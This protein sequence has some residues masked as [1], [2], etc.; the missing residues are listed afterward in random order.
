MKL[1]RSFL[2][3]NLAIVFLSTS[4]VLGR[5]IQMEP[6][7]T[8]WWRCIIALVIMFG[9]VKFMKLE[10]KPKKGHK[11]VIF[12]SAFLLAVHW[13]AYFY[14]LYLSNIAITL[15]A[16]HT[17]PTMTALLEPLI[18]KTKF[19]AYH[20]LLSFLILIG[21]YIIF[22]TDGESQNIIY[23]IIAGLISALAYALRNIYTRKVIGDYDGSVMMFYQLVIM[24]VL[25]LPFL[26][27]ESNATFKVDWPFIVGVAIITTCLGHTL[28]VRN[29]KKYT[30]STI[31]LLVSIV[32]VY[33]ILWGVIFL[34]EIPN[35]KVLIGGV[36]ILTSFVIESRKSA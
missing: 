18:L 14:S 15:I 35:L 32:P 21:L 5:P 6:T 2:E 34:N 17:F 13:V 9:F 10:L 28:F 12:L 3:L 22:P 33:G 31:S 26:F 1:N 8:I 30:A 23:G 11:P 16:L 20:L 4:G 27:I 25:L 7:L 36:L 19:K 29:L 24:T